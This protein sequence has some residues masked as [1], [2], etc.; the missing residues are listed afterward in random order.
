MKERPILF[1][2]S[3]VR[4]ILEGRKTMT[5]RVV[6]PQHLNMVEAVLEANGRWV[7]ETIDYE[8]TTPHGR[9]GDRLWV[10]ETWRT[11]KSLDHLSPRKIS[12]G[13]IVDCSAGYPNKRIY[14]NSPILGMGKWR[15]SIFMPRWASRINLEITGVKVE[16][17]QD[18]SEEDAKA[19]GCHHG[20]GAGNWRDSRHIFQDLW[21]SING[22][23]QGYSWGD[24]PYVWAVS[25]K[26]V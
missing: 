14:D 4:A 3:M 15:P 2:G 23:R 8:L 12:D 20:P 19:E 1:S 26:V 13:A 25:F 7:F 16:R 6:K 18:I 17:L 9:P 21:D 10:R 11:Y 5:R 24:N 22:K